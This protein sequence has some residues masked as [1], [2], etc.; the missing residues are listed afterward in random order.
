MNESTLGLCRKITVLQW[1]KRATRNFVSASHLIFMTHGTLLIEHTS[2]LR[3]RS[4][5]WKTVLTLCNKFYCRKGKVL[6]QTFYFML[7]RS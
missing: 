4:R 7:Q 3:E 1:S 6:N 2:R 5:I